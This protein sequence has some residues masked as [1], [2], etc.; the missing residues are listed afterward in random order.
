MAIAREGVI[1]KKMATT[2]DPAFMGVSLSTVVRIAYHEIPH[3][4][5]TK[6]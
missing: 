2:S 4:R 1:A 6:P 3:R 5:F